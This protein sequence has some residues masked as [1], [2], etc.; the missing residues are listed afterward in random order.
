MT[1]VRYFLLLVF[2]VFWK[3]LQAQAPVSDTTLNNLALPPGYTTAEWGTVPVQHLGSGKQVLLLLPG[4]GFDGS[5]FRDFIQAHLADYSM[6]L[7]TLPGYGDTRAYPMP[8]EGTSYGEGTWMRGVE[9]GILHLLDS[10]H[11]EHPVLVAHFAVS[12]HI[13]LQLAVEHPDRF[14]RVVLVGAPALFRN[15]PPYDTLDLTGR[16]RS[17]DRYLAPRWFKTVTLDT[18]RNGNFPAGVYSCDSLR[19]RDLFEQANSAPLPVQ[20]RY[21]CETWAADFDSYAGVRVPVLALLPSFPPAL[22]ANPMNLYLPWYTE[23]WLKLAGRNPNIRPVR[24]DGAGCNIM[25]DQPERFGRLL[26][27]FLK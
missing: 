8:P 2:L 21:L 6:Y 10:E 14:Q 13:A 1:L 17:V 12:G 9:Q 3:L 26:A 24:V 23:E 19:G 15:P 16:I 22:L 18:W 25:Q 4:W 20:I 11:L 7:L 5:V 27:D